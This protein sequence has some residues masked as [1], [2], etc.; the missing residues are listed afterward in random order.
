MAL[1]LGT[2]QLAQAYG[3][4]KK[5]SKSTAFEV[6]SAAFDNGIEHIDTA[7]F[8]GEAESIIG[9]FLKSNGLKARIC[10]KIPKYTGSDGKGFVDHCKA[11]SINSMRAL[12]RGQLWAI[13]LHDA[14]NA[15]DFPAEVMGLRAWFVAT[16]LVQKFGV[17]L[18]Q[19]TDI[20]HRMMGIYQIPLSM[21][22]T[23]FVQEV[24]PYDFF[25]NG[26]TIMVR[27]I[28]LQGKILGKAFAM[29][30]A[31]EAIQKRT[32]NFVIVVGCET[33]EQV[34][35]N[36]GLYNK[37]TAIDFDHM[38]EQSKASDLAEIDPRKWK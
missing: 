21:K 33:P 17:S 10:T 14:Q 35:E 15:K 31:K 27:S 3:L 22:D 8:Y 20:A 16:G 23:R 13:L 24:P 34:K 19:P 1:C 36:A 38:M 25:W 12:G 30:F 37:E 4:A 6:L 26:N 32:K 28:Y 11:S 2:A 29:Q 18:Y 7:P 5:P 9:T